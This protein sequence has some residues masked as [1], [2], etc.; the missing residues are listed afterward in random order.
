[1]YLVAPQ[2]HGTFINAYKFAEAK[3]KTLNAFVLFINFTVKGSVIMMRFNS[4]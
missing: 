4:N 1:M 2:L 3:N